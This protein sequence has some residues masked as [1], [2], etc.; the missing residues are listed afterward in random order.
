LTNEAPR[1]AEAGAHCSAPGGKTQAVESADRRD[2]GSV[3]VVAVFVS[4]VS[5]SSII[6][7]EYFTAPPLRLF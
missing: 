1:G 6:S 3:S 7:M 2:G 4:A 5:M